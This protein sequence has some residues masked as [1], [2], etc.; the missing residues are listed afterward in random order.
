MVSVAVIEAGGFYEVDNGNYSIV[1]G[2]ALSAPFLTTAESYPPQPLIDWGLVS[3]PQPGAGNRRIHYAQGKTLAGSSALNV[4]AY[5]RATNGTYQRWA[6][7][8]GDDS[9]SFSS[10]LPF[11]ERSCQLTPPN[12]SKRHI[13]NA[14]VPYDST[15]FSRS[16]GPLQVSW[17]NWVDPVLTWFQRAFASID[18]P[19][20]PKNF[21][22]GSLS[23]FSAWIPSTISPFR[24]V[25]SSSQTAFLTE[26]MN[27]TGLVVY[28]HALAKRILFRSEESASCATGVSVTTQDAAFTISARKEVILSAGVFHSP[29]LLMV[30]GRRT[31]FIRRALIS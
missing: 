15:V 30:S 22:S 16:G 19:I 31:S 8:V 6:E 29:Q 10:L 2:L 18:L 27:K 1:P 21:N 5:H 7:L 26:A 9:Y 20:S 23:G 3:T 11:F 28:T 4:M 24:A 25:R 14:S 12:E 17:S 13:S